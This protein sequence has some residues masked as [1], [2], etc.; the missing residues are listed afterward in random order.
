MALYYSEQYVLNTYEDLHRLEKRIKSDLGISER[1]PKLLMGDIWVK[2]NNSTS[3]EREQRTL[4]K[5][6]GAHWL[7][8]TAFYLGSFSFIS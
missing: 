7:P 5:Q 1:A 2:L 8:F 6:W 3:T 4:M